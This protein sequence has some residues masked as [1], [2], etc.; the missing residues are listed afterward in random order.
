[1][2]FFDQ[3]RTKPN[4]SNSGWFGSGDWITIYFFFFSIFAKKINEK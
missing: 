4:Q 2:K 3:I 1:M